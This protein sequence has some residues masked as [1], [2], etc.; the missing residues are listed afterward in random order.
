MRVMLGLLWRGWVNDAVFR[1]R[2][3]FFFHRSTIPL[4]TTSSHSQKYRPRLE[5]EKSLETRFVSTLFTSSIPLSITTT[6]RVIYS[7]VLCR[8][9]RLGLHTKILPD[10]LQ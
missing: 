5:N 7:K 8:P 6:I 1:R 3:F 2:T 10:C 4:S 9:A